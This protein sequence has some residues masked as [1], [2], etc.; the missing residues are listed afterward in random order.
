[1]S[2]KIENEFSRPFNLDQV[3]KSGS[4]VSIEADEQERKK[5]ASRLELGTHLAPMTFALAFVTWQR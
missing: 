3:K 5:L 1:M 2:E 4:H